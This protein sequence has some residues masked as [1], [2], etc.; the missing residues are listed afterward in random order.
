MEVYPEVKG[1]KVEKITQTRVEF[2][3]DIKDPEAISSVFMEPCTIDFTIEKNAF[4]DP[5]KHDVIE[6]EKVDQLNDIVFPS[7][8]GERR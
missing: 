5:Q 4:I 8:A 2:Q 3:L 1:F 6:L 7:H